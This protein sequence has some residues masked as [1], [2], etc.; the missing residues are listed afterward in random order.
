MIDVQYEDDPTKIAINYLR[1]QFFYDAVSIFPYNILKKNFLGLRLV[2][3]RMF[4]KYQ[5]YINE[6]LTENSSF[7]LMSNESMIKI[8]EFYNMII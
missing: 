3:I 7:F 2:K 5:G 4:T 1:G 8:V 6:F